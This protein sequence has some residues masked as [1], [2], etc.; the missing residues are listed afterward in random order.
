MRRLLCPSFQAHRT[1]A[2]MN[3]RELSIATF[4]LCTLKPQ[5]A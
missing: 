1:K 3:Q 5:R 2:A 4:N